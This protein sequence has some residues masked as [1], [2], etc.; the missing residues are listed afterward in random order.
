MKKVLFALLMSAGLFA[1][2]KD[3]DNKTTNPTN[4]NTDTTYK[5]SS[6]ITQAEA[7]SEHNN[8][9]AGVYKGV[10]VGSSGTIA[11]YLFNTGTEVKALVAFDGKNATL[12]ST[13]LGSWSPG[14]PISNAPFTGKIDGKD[15]SAT[16]SV[17]SMG[18]NPRVQ[19]Q[20][21][22]HDVKVAI[23]K[24]TSTTVIKNYE[25]T[26]TGDRSGTYN[27]TLN[28]SDFYIVTNSGDPFSGTLVNGKVA[29]NK[30]QVEI[31]GEFKGDEV[32]GT[33]KDGKKGTQ[34]TW[35]GKRTL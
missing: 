27:L 11:I 28:G 35:K 7:K 2:S 25:G 9:T 20:I 5:C 10:L 26:Y 17:D 1:C 34:G 18:K 22:G 19:V 3:D 13:A 33:W 30:D 24:E 14:M 29:I 4:N 21:P 12:T 6:C 16:F 8:S 32:T 15:M 31:N 23:Y